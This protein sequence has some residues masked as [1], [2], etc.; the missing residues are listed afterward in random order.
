M[1]ILARILFLTDG[2]TRTLKI[3]VEDVDIIF[4]LNLGS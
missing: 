2:A 1:Y 4:L 3:E